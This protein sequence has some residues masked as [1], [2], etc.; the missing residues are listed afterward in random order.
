VFLLLC[1]VFAAVMWMVDYFQN[2]RPGLLEAESRQHLS[3]SSSGKCYVSDQ[4]I[5]QSVDMIL[6]CF[7]LV[8]VIRMVISMKCIRG[9]AEASLHGQRGTI[10]LYGWMTIVH[11]PLIILATDSLMFW[12]QL[13]GAAQA[14]EDMELLE[15]FRHFASYSSLVSLLCC[16]LHFWHALLVGD[17]LRQHQPSGSSSKR[18][19]PAGFVETMSTVPYDPDL[20]GQ[21]DGR[22]YCGECPICLGDFGPE[23]EIKVTHCGHAFH[24]ECLGHWLRKERT[25]A[26]CRRDVTQQ[27]AAEGAEEAMSATSSSASTA[28]EEAMSAST[29]ST[30]TE[31]EVAAE[32][33]EEAM[34]TGAR[35]A[36]RVIGCPY[37]RAPRTDDATERQAA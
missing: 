15:I 20:F 2:A 36:A 24:K 37:G 1:T 14:C 29:S 7:G 33:A 5:R 11:G 28:A 32:A 21:E 13:V 26:L 17:A 12:V 4:Q 27:A 18:R 6:G 16:L 3:E 19:A 35:P 10:A 22:Q 8:V 23:E 31:A 25:C 9:V 30:S 34:S